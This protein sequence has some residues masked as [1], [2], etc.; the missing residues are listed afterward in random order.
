MS[1][2]LTTKH[3]FSSMAVFGLLGP[4][5]EGLVILK[6]IRNFSPDTVSHSRRTLFLANNIMR[7]SNMPHYQTHCQANYGTPNLP[8]P[9]YT[10]IYIHIHNA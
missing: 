4:E 9:T 1:T 5:G 2:T 8:V 10:Y 6:N 7:T 3:Y